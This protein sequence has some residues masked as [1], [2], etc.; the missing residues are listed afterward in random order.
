MTAIVLF[1]FCYVIGCRGKKGCW[2]KNGVLVNKD[3][4]NETIVSKNKRKNKTKQKITPTPTKYD[5]G[6]KRSFG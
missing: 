1:F 6:I 3:N 4:E 5:E 2:E